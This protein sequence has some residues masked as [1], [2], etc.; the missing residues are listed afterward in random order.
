[1]IAKK[2][3]GLSLIILGL[4]LGS[5][6]AFS[7]GTGELTGAVTDKSN[8]EALIGANIFLE[9]TS[10]GISTDLDG[11]YSI[12]NIPP[13]SY[14]VRVSYIG[15]KTIET[16]IEVKAGEKHVQN[17]ILVATGVEGKEVVVTA[18]AQ[19]QNAAI[20]QQ[21]A[22][23][24]IINVVSA[25]RIK[26]L[27]DANA[28]ESIGRLPGVF[29]VRD[30][31]EGS[32]VAIRG[33]EPKY[34]KIMIDG[35]EMPSN[36]AGSSS[37]GGD[38]GVDMSM[39]SSDMLSGIE[40]YKTVTAD[41]DAAVLGGT[42]NFQ[43][44]EAHGTSS[45]QPLVNLSAQGRY[46][47]LQN[48]Y[49]DYKFSASG[50]QRFLDDQLGVF[51]LGIAERRNLTADIFGGTYDVQ[52]HDYYHPV[53]VIMNNLNLS[54][55]PT[56]RHRYDG[57]IVMDY[58][59]SDGKIDLMNVFSRSDQTTQT[60]GQNYN[61]AG[62][63]NSITY[64]TAYYDP[65]QNNIQNVLDLQQNVLFFKMDAKV[66]H[67]YAENINPGYWSA[68]FTQGSAGVSGVNQKEN[69]EMTAQDASAFA[70]L[71]K[72][73]LSGLS[74]NSSFTRQRNVAGSIDF[75]SDFNFSDLLSG[76]LKFGGMY[77][78]TF[79]SYDYSAGSGSNLDNPAAGAEAIR[80]AIIA[81]NP[82]M[83]Q[84]PY[85]LRTNGFDNLPIGVFFNQSSSFGK[86]LGGSYTLLGRPT[87][88]GLVSNVINQIIVSQVGNGAS[89]GNYYAPDEKA[90]IADDYSGNEDL[91]AMYIMSTIHVGDEITFI[92]GVR[93]QGLQTH[94]TAAYI[95]YWGAVN[96]YPFSFT[97]TDTTVTRYHG[98]WLPD[99]SLRYK[100]L[101]WLDTRISYTNTLS[102]PDFSYIVPETHI[103]SSVTPGI[104]EQWNNVNLKPARSQNFDLS[105]SLYNN[106]IGLFTVAPFLKRI[107]D[108]IFTYGG[109]GITN[110]AIYPLPASTKNYTL[111]NTQINNPNRVDL[112]GTEFDWQTHF[113]YLP[114]V[115][116]GLV[117]NTN[118]THIF[119]QAKYPIHFSETVGQFPNFRTL[120]VDTFY[121]AR[122]IDQPANIINLT[123]GY[124]YKGFSLQVSMIYQ[125]DVF[126][127]TAF[128]PQ[129]RK[130]KSTYRRWD[131]AGKQ[132]LPWEGLELFFDVNNLNS[133]AD[134]SVVQGT[135]FPSSDDSYGATADFGLRWKF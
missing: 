129:L 71:D 134:I 115:L 131:L 84:P 121:T 9:G 45:G 15:Y 23:D 78:Y 43:I 70:K 41:M 58:R 101:T 39:I 68:T 1:M 130:S 53:P 25:A 107:D 95:P 112:Y 97:H 117:L 132:A 80:A 106:E 6:F 62:N 12:K 135:G 90:D 111:S 102:Y 126:D 51:V 21:L 54:Y 77:K 124:D 59:W 75:E 30:Y 74:T 35:V 32:E 17:F 14:T 47:D 11:N 64:S 72:T 98:Y 128:W 61:I 116:S 4:F 76:Q 31:G 37:A 19:G 50:E 18:Q 94:Y 125:A 8:D 104:V 85:N 109:F 55:K 133:E 27:P 10:L 93:Y 92:P 24:K 81:A 83:A 2:S 118:Y 20:N 69:P 63:N 13:G 114:S 123:L 42:V 108:F 105:L 36:D 119:S 56:D 40:L 67:A 79:R 103:N 3:G 127:G 91:N 87:N 33:L 89:T 26:E 49:H 66:S 28:A 7:Q 65:R 122:L 52:T 46:D 100:P 73:D 22:S 86:F 38:R 60:Y 16:P 57:T 34:S 5:Q 96:T 110:P 88:L 29:L 82:W 99:A 113:W 48:T 120:E 44:R